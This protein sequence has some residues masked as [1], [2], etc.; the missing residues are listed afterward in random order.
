[1][2]ESASLLGDDPL[3]PR[4]SMHDE[5]K[6]DITAMIDLVFMMNIFFLVTTV[7]AALAEIDLPSAKHCAPA[8]RDNAVMITIMAP[9]DQGP[10]L[11][12]L[13]DAGEG[14]PLPEGDAEERA[15]KDAVQ[16]GV[17][18]DK[19]IVLIKAERNVRL[20]DVS[21][22]GSLAVSVPGTELKLAVI[23]KE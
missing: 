8:D 14:R 10:S 11:V 23:E 1:M 16:A 3:F 18:A 7:T 2:S 6:F 9:V 13:G 20:R 5:A 12:Y 22:I 19:K 17:R 21:R 4:K 15:I